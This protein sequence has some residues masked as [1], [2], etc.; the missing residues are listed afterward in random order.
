MFSL[1]LSLETLADF[2]DFSVNLLT[3]LVHVIVIS[4]DL[5]LLTSD[6]VKFLLGCIEV[7]GQLLQISLLS[8]EGF[9]SCS[10][11]V[12]QDL[13]SLQISSLS[14]LSELISVVLVSDL[15][16]GK[17]IQERLNFFLALLHF[18]IKLISLS[19]KLLLD[20]LALDNI[21]CL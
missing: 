1:V 15:Q 8:E 5:I 16:M 17:C 4:L 7:V 2:I 9:S 11:L 19:L 6:I 20:L 18:S 12:I 13:L 14:T 21:V 3:D 10:I